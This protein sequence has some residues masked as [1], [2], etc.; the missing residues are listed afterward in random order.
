MEHMIVLFEQSILSG[1]CLVSVAF[2]RDRKGKRKDLSYFSYL[3][4]VELEGLRNTVDLIKIIDHCI[5]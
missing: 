4:S 1:Q 2:G 5:V 3:R